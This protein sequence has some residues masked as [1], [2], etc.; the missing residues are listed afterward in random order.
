MVF[1]LHSVTEV[2]AENVILI[3]MNTTTLWTLKFLQSILRSAVELPI[4]YSVD[5][6]RY[7]PREKTRDQ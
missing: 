1:F 7:D 3:I 6:L 2:D 4:K 5:P